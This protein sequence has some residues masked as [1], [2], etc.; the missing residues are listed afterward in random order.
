[1]DTITT[2]TRP[3]TTTQG[4]E[5]SR[6]WECKAYYYWT[7]VAPRQNLWRVLPSWREQSHCQEEI[8]H[9][10]PLHPP[11][12]CLSRRL[13]SCRLLRV[14]RRGHQQGDLPHQ[15]QGRGVWPGR[16]AGQRAPDDIRPH[17]VPQRGR[18]VNRLSHSAGQISESFRALYKFHCRFVSP[19]VLT[20]TSLPWKLSVT[21]WVRMI[22]RPS[23]G[24]S[25]SL[26]GSLRSERSQSS[27][28]WLRRSAHPGT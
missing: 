13:G 8:L 15:L 16:H 2:T 25:V 24:H 19:N 5:V 21:A 23:C 9:W 22:S 26:T 17:S 14:H 28:S 27:P 18:H 6:V 4:W 12:L 7:S 10:R 1:M 11:L 20:R 3:K